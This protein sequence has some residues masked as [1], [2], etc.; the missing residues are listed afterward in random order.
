[1][2]VTH[3]ESLM[4][5][6]NF[7][8]IRRMNRRK[9]VCCWNASRI[10]SSTSSLSDSD[11]FWTMKS[12]WVVFHRR[13]SIALVQTRLNL[14]F[15]LVE[16]LFPTSSDATTISSDGTITAELSPDRCTVLVAGIATS[17]RLGML[18]LVCWDLSWTCFAADTT[19][20]LLIVTSLHTELWSGSCFISSICCI[21]TADEAA[22]YE[23]FQPW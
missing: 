13:V 3:V 10:S 15:S 17:R 2:N 23:R 12:V 4:N 20:G 14:T 1:M 8:S 18:W 11:A 21:N 6:R 16:T 19:A 7:C 22:T 9:R 5:C